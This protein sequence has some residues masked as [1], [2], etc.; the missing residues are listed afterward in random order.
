[1][2]RGPGESVVHGLWTSSLRHW[3]WGFILWRQALGTRD[4]GTQIYIKILQ[5]QNKSKALLLISGVILLALVKLLRKVRNR[6]V[7]SVFTNLH[8]NSTT[9]YATSI[10][11]QLEFFLKVWCN[12]NWFTNR[13]GFLL[14]K[15]FAVSSDQKKWH[16]MPTNASVD[17]PQNSYNI[18]P[19]NRWTSFLVFGVGNLYIASSLALIG[20]TLPWPTH[21][22]N[23]QH[24]LEK[25]HFWSN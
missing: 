17:R 20:L 3:W 19:R 8:E 10:Y 23:K 7:Y 2:E 18:Q 9:P 25:I 12:Q 22:L 16:T 24:W 13:Y 4:G 14:L 15:P 11:G 21:G 6:V 1:M 5:W